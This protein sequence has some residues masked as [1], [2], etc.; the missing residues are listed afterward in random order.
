MTKAKHEQAGV[1][2]QTPSKPPVFEYKD[3]LVADSRDVA[4]RLERHHRTLIRS[5]RT[6]CG[7]LNQHNFVPVDFFIPA[8]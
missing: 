6:Y 5:I 1:P 7:Y 4:A 3:H 8:T 2:V